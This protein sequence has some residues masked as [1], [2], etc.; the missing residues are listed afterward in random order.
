MF[1]LSPSVVPLDD[2]TI[3]T[4]RSSKIPIEKKLP[5]LDFITFNQGQN[6]SQVASPALGGTSYGPLSNVS[7]HLVKDNI[8]W[9]DTA[10]MWPLGN[11]ASD[12]FSDLLIGDGMS[13][14]L[15]FM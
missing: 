4:P 8:L 15:I 6:S 12:I 7:A 1:T 9:C 14:L 2:I 3:S 10:A 11:Q 5:I 13:S